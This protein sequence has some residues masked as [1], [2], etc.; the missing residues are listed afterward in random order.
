MAKTLV[1]LAGLVQEQVIL[2]IFQRDRIPCLYAGVWKK[3]MIAVVL[4][5]GIYC[6]RT[7]GVNRALWDR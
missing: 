5:K 6:M 7:I 3:R 1:D 2:S 4:F